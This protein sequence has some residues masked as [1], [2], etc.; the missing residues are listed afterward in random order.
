MTWFLRLIRSVHWFYSA[1]QSQKDFAMLTRQLSFEIG[2]FNSGGYTLWGDG[3]AARNTT[4]LHALALSVLRLSCNVFLVQSLFPL[5]ARRFGPVLFTQHFVPGSLSKAL[6]SAPF[7]RP[8]ALAPS[9]WRT[10]SNLEGRYQ[11]GVVYDR[12]ACH[13]WM[14]LRCAVPPRALPFGYQAVTVVSRTL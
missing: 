11:L 9:P 5:G 13:S 14:C 8:V 4:F 2:F 7:C 1:R 10:L 12:L 6:C 3:K